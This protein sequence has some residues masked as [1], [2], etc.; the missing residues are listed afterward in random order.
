MHSEGWITKLRKYR[1]IVW[2]WLKDEHTVLTE[3]QLQICAFKINFRWSL[4]LWG[5]NVCRVTAASFTHRSPSLICPVTLKHTKTEN[6]SE[7]III[8]IIIPNNGLIA[9]CHSQWVTHTELPVRDRQEK[10]FN[11]F[12]LWFHGG[13]AG[14]RLFLFY[15]FSLIFINQLWITDLFLAH[16][17]HSCLL[18]CRASLSPVCVRESSP[19]NPSFLLRGG[20]PGLNSTQHPSHVL[21]WWASWGKGGGGGGMMSLPTNNNHP[22]SQLSS[23]SPGCLATPQLSPLRAAP[24]PLP[25]S[26]PWRFVNHLP[27]L[28][29]VMDPINK[30]DVA[31]VKDTFTSS[32]QRRTV[33]MNTYY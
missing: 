16:N 25:S 3:A 23:L 7:I 10:H 14:R 33:W 12:S 1:V 31:P 30:P 4:N 9:A 27:S 18:I 6:G 19:N 8:R 11:I 26:G 13:A 21:Q 17:T 20:L 2:A 32:V 15:C 29:V 28:A 24:P 22:A 5:W